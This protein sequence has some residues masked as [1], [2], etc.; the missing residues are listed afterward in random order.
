MIKNK[1]S[2]NFRIVILSRE[3]I[4]MIC[5]LCAILTTT[6]VSALEY[7]STTGIYKVTVNT[8]LS[9]R[10]RPST[11]SKKIGSLNNNEQIS[12]LG[13]DNGWARIS[14]NGNMGYV[15]SQYLSPVSVSSPQKH[16]SITFMPCGLTFREALLYLM[17]IVFVLRFIGALFFDDTIFYQVLIFLQPA[18][19]LLYV[20][21]VDDPMWFCD[22]DRLG[23]II[24][25]FN[26]FCLGVYMYFMLMTMWDF[27]CISFHSF[28]FFR[29][30]MIVLLGFAL[31]KVGSVAIEQLVTLVILN[32]LGAIASGVSKSGS[33]GYDDTI[34]IEDTEGKHE[35]RETSFGRF[36][37][38][39]DHRKTWHKVGERFIRDN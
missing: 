34:I 22:P 36:T 20:Y 21:T 38:I 11:T 8:Y 26:V 3:F 30:L 23:Y 29:L 10:E 24:A 25:Y 14:I 33:R 27:L 15:S 6:K 18:L 1:L 12:V 16:F 5:C 7:T 35:V 17:V 9:I 19:A 4:M 39:S 31:F 37:D 28:S 32:V 2:V 13:I